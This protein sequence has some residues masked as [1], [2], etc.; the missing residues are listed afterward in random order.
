[1]VIIPL[2][3]N[4]EGLSSQFGLLSCDAAEAFARDLFQAGGIEHGDVPIAVRDQ[5]RLLQRTRRGCHPGS[6]YRQH[7]REKFL[8]E[9]QLV[10]ADPVTRQQQPTGKALLKAVTAVAGGRLRDLLV[11]A[12]RVPGKMSAKYLVCI[13]RLP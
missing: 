8:R 13:E 10:G 7:H 4:T 1:M 3:S 12:V 6:P 11:E 5:T 2:R 9:R